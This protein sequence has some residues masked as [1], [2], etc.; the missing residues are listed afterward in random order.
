VLP[1]KAPR[2]IDLEVSLEGGGASR[3]LRAVATPLDESLSLAARRS[4]VFVQVWREGHE[5]VRGTV[6]HNDS[7]TVA[8]FQGTDALFRIA[9]ALGLRVVRKT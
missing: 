8:Y 6:T 9:E 2:T 7:G 3:A 4:S 5:V 1:E